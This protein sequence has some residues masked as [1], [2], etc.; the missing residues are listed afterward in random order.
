M[1]GTQG[2]AAPGRRKQ[3][4]PRGGCAL[5]LALA[6]SLAAC[7]GPSGS[8][9]GNTPP[10]PTGPSEAQ[11]NTTDPR[12]VLQ[13]NPRAK[14]AV[15]FIHGIFGDTLGT[16]THANGTRFFDLL[17]NAPD[18]GD[19][20]D[21]YAF[22]FTSR[23]FGEGS[24]DI[25]EA[26]LKLH[27]YLEYHG[28]T[29][30]DSVVFVA[31]S[32]GGLVA[33][34]ELISHSDFSGKVP[35]LMLYATP[36]E[37]SDITRI[38]KYVVANN[39]IRQMLPAD[40]NDY[41]K[42]LSDDWTGLKASGRAPKVICAYEL[43][44]THGVMIVPWTSATRFCDEAPPGIADADHLSI[45]KPDRQEHE[46]VVKL[47]NA[48]R[49]YALPRM[50]ESSWNTPNFV[51]EGEVWTYSLLDANEINHAG[52]INTSATAQSYS[53]EVPQASKLI[54]LPEVT[55]RRVQA[56]SHEDL[57]LFVIGTPQPEYRFKLY[58]ASLPERTVVVRIPHLAA[59]RAARAQWLERT[60]NA[61]NERIDASGEAAFERLPDTDKWQQLAQAAQASIAEGLPELPAS[62]RWIATADA[63]SELGLADSSAVALR[64]VEKDYPQIAR[65][66]AVLNLSQEVSVKIKERP[67]LEGPARYR[68]EPIPPDLLRVD[69]EIRKE[70]SSNKPSQGPTTL[71]PNVSRYSSE[72]TPGALAR[73]VTPVQVEPTKRAP[74]GSQANTFSRQL[75]SQRELRPA[76]E[77]VAQPSRVAATAS[78]VLHESPTRSTTEMQVRVSPS[79]SET[80]Q[81]APSVATPVPDD[82]ALQRPRL[83]T[84][85]R[86]LLRD[87]LTRSGAEPGE[88]EPPASRTES[89]A[90]TATTTT[91]DAIGMQRRQIDAAST[92]QQ[93][94]PRHD[95]D[96]V[97]TQD[98]GSGSRLSQTPTTVTTTAPA[99]AATPP[100]TSPQQPVAPSNMQLKRVSVDP[101]PD[102][103]R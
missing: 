3:R 89:S 2:N 28:V 66:S 96:E 21:I 33:M 11:A 50:Q 25:R 27:E 71:T 57:R 40:G 14:I 4:R 74:I 90:V 54:V 17:K 10:T 73:K 36:Q 64:T 48:L 15:V 45:V 83:G 67:T 81:P 102:N 53:I 78:S 72:V 84:R 58:L 77:M 52:L 5:A 91:P 47:A 42:Q 68:P 65:T 63:L 56:G 97:R 44:S 39:A 34:R 101:P 41:L 88:Q 60:A 19:K 79:L 29:G 46:S 49:R 18:V 62:A 23:M 16:W 32:M 85:V 98:M 86:S 75:P 93:N 51:R 22:G 95:A 13:G 82:T 94:A 37:G 70:P 26:S 8:S 6:L 35:L 24:Q 100:S 61:I 80:E 69:P 55:P 1:N 87:V 30:Y 7:H 43:K 12:W 38:A 92:L 31:H 103:D 99:T 20:V 76:S 9:T 59:V